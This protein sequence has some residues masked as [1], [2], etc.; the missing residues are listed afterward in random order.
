[1]NGANACFICSARAPWSVWEGEWRPVCRRHF[2]IMRWDALSD[3]ERGLPEDLD[4]QMAYLKY[5]EESEKR[6]AMERDYLA[7]VVSG[8]M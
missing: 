5:K 2:V 3:P 4:L 7:G 8:R 6:G 1:M